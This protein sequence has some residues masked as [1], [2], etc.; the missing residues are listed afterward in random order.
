MKVKKGILV[1]GGPVNYPF[2][3]HE[4]AKEHD[5]LIAVDGG[6]RALAD[7]GR[8]PTVVVGDYDSL[9][10]SGLEQL[11]GQGVQLLFDEHDQERTDLEIGL[12]FAVEQ[13]LTELVVF[14]GLGGRLDHTL[15]NLSS[16]YQMKLKRKKMFLVGPEQLVT[17][18]APG[19]QVVMT[20]FA[21]GH[22][23]LLPY[24]TTVSGVKVAGARYPLEEATL[25]LGSTLG[26]HNEYRTAPVGVGVGNGYLLLIIEG[27]AHWPGGMEIFQ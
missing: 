3:R 27:L 25:T 26:I 2:L 5:L 15:A 19:E 11:K 10:P 14:G 20:P 23:S 24:S 8:L 9:A 4:L 22:F 7:L 6:C 21:G 16:L 17:M 13:D 1:G 18:L 12:E